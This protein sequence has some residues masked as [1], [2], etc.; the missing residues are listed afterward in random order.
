M[1]ARFGYPEAAIP[2][3]ASAL[4]NLNRY[5]RYPTCSAAHRQA[6]QHLKAE[7]VSMLYAL[8][9]HTDR[10]VELQRPRDGKRCF[11]CNGDGDVEGEACP[12][13]DGTG[14]FVSPRLDILYAF[15]FTISGLR[16]S[17]I[18]PEG[19][20][21]MVP[22]V[23]ETR[24]ES[25]FIRLEM[26]MDLRPDQLAEAKAIVRFALGHMRRIQHDP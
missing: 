25:S 19:S 2:A 18:V 8:E 3:A 5:T 23:E 22:D 7:F 26:S 16:Y 24:T 15:T 12:K 11:S 21:G 17:W 10:V 14:W 13:C 1:R 9:Q 4:F 20:L 6:I